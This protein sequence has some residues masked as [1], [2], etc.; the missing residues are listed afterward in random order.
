LIANWFAAPGL[1]T[2]RLGLVTSKQVGPAVVRN[3]ARRL[4]REC[5][6]LHQH[7]LVGPLDLVLVARPSMARKSWLEVEHDFLKAVRKANLL[8][9]AKT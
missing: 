9:T 1:Q 5:Y 7:E 2:T 3:R 6:R 8:K 4:M